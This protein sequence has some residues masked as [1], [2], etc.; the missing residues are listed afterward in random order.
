VEDVVSMA[1]VTMQQHMREHS[2]STK[3][4]SSNDQGAGREGADVEMQQQNMGC[5]KFP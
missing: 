3:I 5:S 1:Q 2:N 4:V